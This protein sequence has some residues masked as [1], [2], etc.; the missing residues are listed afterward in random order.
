L[1]AL[2]VCFRASVHGG[3]H[4]GGCAFGGMLESAEAAAAASSVSAGSSPAAAHVAA[5]FLAAPSRG[6]PLHLGSSPAS[7]AE[8]AAAGVA[9]AFAGAVAQ[10]RS[11]N[12]RGRGFT[13]SEPSRS[14]WCIVR[15]GAAD[16]PS[17]TRTKSIW[18][19]LGLEI[20]APKE[21]IRR[22]YKQFVLR[23][24]PDTNGGRIDPEFA[25]KFEQVTILYKEIMDADEDKFWLERF[26][27]SAAEKV[28]EREDRWT[29]R[30]E[31]NKYARMYA[32]EAAAAERAANGEP[33]PEEALKKEEGPK[34]DQILL[35]TIFGLGGFVFLAF[36]S[37]VVFMVVPK[38]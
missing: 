5:A 37:M 35:G 3:W 4:L 24:H 23:S 15:A 8:F 26:D 21:E 38:S 16:M 30:Q 13:G 1:L 27:A 22:G 9:A 33:E 28:R 34:A 12:R 31:Y 14:S 11:A 7:G 2:P 17:P 32:A 29:A 36:M 10:R 19:L 25:E 18:V 6:V 20:G